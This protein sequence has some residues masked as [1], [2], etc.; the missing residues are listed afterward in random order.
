VFGLL[1]THKI[2]TKGI[3][4]WEISAKYKEKYKEESLGDTKPWWKHNIYSHVPANHGVD[5]W[6]D[7][8]YSNGT[9]KK[10]K[11]VCSIMLV[12]H[13]NIRYHIEAMNEDGKYRKEYI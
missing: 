12:C 2:Y 5:E 8:H 11:L 10:D 13:I 1:Q 4:K 7:E 9:I 6:G 3:Y